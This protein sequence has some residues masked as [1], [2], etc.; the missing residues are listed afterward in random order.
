MLFVL[1]S[2][3][4]LMA[5][6]FYEFFY[7]KVGLGALSYYLSLSGF[8]DHSLF[9]LELLLVFTYYMNENF[10]AWTGKDDTCSFM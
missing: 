10:H 1:F 9:F 3:K 2:D 4:H 6:C 8:N 7:L 5:V